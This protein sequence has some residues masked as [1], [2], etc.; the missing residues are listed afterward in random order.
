MPSELLF[1]L[2]LVVM[3]AGLGCFL[4]AYRTRLDTPVHKRWGIAGTL[5]SLGGICVVLLATYL[6]GWRVEQRFPEV[7][8]WHRRLALVSVS[9]LILTALTGMLR[10]RIHTR[11][12]LIFLPVFI[13]ALVTAAIGYRP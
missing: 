9:L 6:W 8:L 11:L 12:Y 10:I 7:V 3:G 13:L 4:K 5:I 2:Y 1:F